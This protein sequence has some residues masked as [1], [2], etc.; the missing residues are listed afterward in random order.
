MWGA[1][2]DAMRDH[3]RDS[4]GA[5]VDFLSLD[6]LRVCPPAAADVGTVVLLLCFPV[7]EDTL[8]LE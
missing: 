6:P 5:P 8:R 4:H 2:M 7:P 3:R 1:H